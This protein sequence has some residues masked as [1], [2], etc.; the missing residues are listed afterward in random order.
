[1]AEIAFILYMVVLQTSKEPVAT[2]MA[3]FPSERDCV[4]AQINAMCA[5]GEPEHRPEVQFV[6]VRKPAQAF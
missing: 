2:E 4:A 6:C 5:P 1:M 3:T